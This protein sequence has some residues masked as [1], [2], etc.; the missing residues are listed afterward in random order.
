[1]IRKLRELRKIVTPPRVL[2]VE[3]YHKRHLHYDREG[4]AAD[5]DFCEKV[6]RAVENGT[7]RGLRN[8]K[9]SFAYRMITY[10]VDADTLGYK[11]DTYAIPQTS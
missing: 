8:G 1:M 6:M 9:H 11:E 10:H 7:Y 5:C 4:E 2:D 3:K